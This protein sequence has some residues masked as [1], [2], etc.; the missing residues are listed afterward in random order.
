MAEGSGN[1]EFA[2]SY[3]SRGEL[4]FIHEA[5]RQY[6]LYDRYFCSILAGTWPNRYYKWSG[7]S[8]GVM[9]NSVAPGGNNWETIFDRATAHGLTVRYYY[10]DLP[11]GA[12][13]G[14]R[15]TPWLA[16]I[17]QYYTDAAAGKLPNIAIVDPAFKD[18]SGGDGLSADEH[19]LGDV[20]LGQAFQADVVNSFV[21]SPNYRRGALFLIYDEW[22]GFF[23]HVKPPKVPDDRASTDLYQDFGQMGFRIPA[24]AISPWSRNN[25]A[26]RGKFGIGFNEHWRVDHGRYGHES[27]LSFLS[28]RFQLGFLTKRHQ[29]ANN[30]GRGFNWRHPNFDPPQLPDPPA[31]LT[32]PCALGGGDVLDSQEAHQSD[33]AALED[34]AD[35]HNVKVYEATPSNIFT[36]PDTVKKALQA[37]P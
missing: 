26:D 3:Y 28:Y 5:A 12:L 2:L 9:N 23:D 13:W 34:Y 32:Q 24:V 4:G 27:I 15:S 19:P 36:K 8:G 30:I 37:A 25:R 22:G 10:S 35:R 14:G 6:T 29:T 21:T 11:F 7:Q 20:R 17:S 33:L 1:D 31:I 18:G 16:P